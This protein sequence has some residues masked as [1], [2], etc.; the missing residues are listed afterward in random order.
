[1]LPGAACF[2]F[3]DLVNYCSHN[4]HVDKKTLSFEQETGLYLLDMR[5]GG[6]F[7]SRL[8]FVDTIVLWHWK[9]NK[10]NERVPGGSH[11]ALGHTGCLKD[12]FPIRRVG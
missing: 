4:S 8:L 11:P 12:A 1:M 9:K 3:I 10:K 5:K 7:Y 2:G 6:Q